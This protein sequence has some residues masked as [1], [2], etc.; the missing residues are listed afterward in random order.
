MT[1]Q[2]VTFKVKIIFISE[3]NIYILIILIIFGQAKVKL[4]VRQMRTH[5]TAWSEGQTAVSL[6]H[7]ISIT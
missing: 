4:V 6:R 1:K 5:T 2:G 7:G 3:K